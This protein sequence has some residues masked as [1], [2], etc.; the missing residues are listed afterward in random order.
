[1]HQRKHISAP[2]GLHQCTNRTASMHRLSCINASVEPHQCTDRAA[3]VH[4]RNCTNAPAAPHQ[5]INRTASMHRPS[6]INAPA[7][8]H[9]CADRAA[10]MH[11]PGRI[12]APKRR[13]DAPLDA[14]HRPC[15][16]PMSRPDALARRCVDS[17]SAHVPPIRQAAAPS[18]HGSGTTPRGGR[19]RPRATTDTRCTRPEPRQ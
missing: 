18:R 16:G 12:N 19:M 11:Q 6:C 7:E 9:Q 13:I 14:S 2:T 5:C 8:P 15:Q 4:Q 10:S 17:A 3:L 1:M